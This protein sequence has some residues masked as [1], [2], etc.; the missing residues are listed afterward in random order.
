MSEVA[1]S[2]VHNFTWCGR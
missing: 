1:M 2:T